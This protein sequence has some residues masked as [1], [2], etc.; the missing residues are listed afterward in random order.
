MIVLEEELIQSIDKLT[1]AISPSPHYFHTTFKCLDTAIRHKIVFTDIHT[2]LDFNSRSIILKTPQSN[3]TAVE[4]S[5]TKTGE[6][7]ELAKNDRLVMDEK[8]EG[9]IY[10]KFSTVNDEF[11]ITVW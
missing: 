11:E 7:K 6:L 8:E 4:Y 1:Q 2:G 10:L 5:F 3:T 9:M